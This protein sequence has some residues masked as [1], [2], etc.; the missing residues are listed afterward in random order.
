MPNEICRR[1]GEDT[2]LIEK[3]PICAQVI[4]SLCPECNV[5]FESFHSE[6]IEIDKLG[7]IV[8]E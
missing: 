2:T 1:C 6:C 5:V 8:I 4:K 3:C 7:K